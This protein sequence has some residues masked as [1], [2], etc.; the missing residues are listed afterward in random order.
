[1][2]TMMGPSGFEQDV[3]HAAAEAL[4]PLVDEVTI[5]RLGSVIGVRRCGKPNAK[6]LLLDAHLDEIGLMVTGVEEGYLRFR[7]IGGVDPRMLPDAEVLIWAE[8]PLLGIVACLPPHVQSASDANKSVPINDLRIDVG[9]TQE[10][11]ELTIPVGTPIT[12][13]SKFLKLQARQICGKT[14]DDRACFAT[15]VH[16]LQLLK[17]KKLDVDLYVMGSTREEVSGAGAAAG[18]FAIH[19]DFCIAVDV[20]HGRTPDAPADKTM[21]IGGGPAIGVGPNMTRW[22]TERMVKKAQEHKIPYQLEVMAGHTGTNGWD[23]QISR[24]GVATAVLSLPLKYM[25][26][27]IETLDISDAEQVAKLI[28]AFAEGLGAEC[29]C[30]DESPRQ[31][32]FVF[33]QVQALDALQPKYM[34]Q[35]PNHGLMNMVAT[36]CAMDGVSSA[37]DCVRDYLMREAKP[38]ASK[39]RVDT[40]GN[41][42]VFKKGAKA[43]GNKLMVCAHMDEVGLMVRAITEEGYLKFSFVGGVDRRVAIGKRVVVGNKRVAGVIGLKAYHLVSAEEE[44]N[45]PKADEFYIDI[46][47]RSKEEAEKLVSLG[48]VAAFDSDVTVFGNGM[49]KAKAIDD[50]V[51]CAIMLELIKEDLPMDCVFAFTAQE[52]VGTRGAFGAAFSVTPEIALVLEGTTAADSP[53]MEPHR[54]VCKPGSGPVLSLMDGGTVY[55]RALF[56]RLRALAE[57]KGIPWQVKHYLSGGTDAKAIQRTKAGIRVTGISA[58]VRYLHAPASVANISDIEN[59]YTLTKAFIESLAANCGQGGRIS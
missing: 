3:A 5:D 41:L 57:E 9:M 15:L 54:K 47:A 50:R 28:A 31:S 44:K 16:A 22:M 59:T 12:Y 35:V 37:E 55:D 7:A 25:H 6:K 20:T 38:Y 49:L 17:G 39:I 45:I 46:G 27:P 32:D 48:D 52:E 33:Q 23:M 24:E 10:E 19:P 58:A 8:K 36:L 18:T 26:S 29:D 14:M 43:T 30:L 34:S 11:A 42:I 2:T 4:R 53:Q 21:K 51:G 56:E 1:M 13:R 40:L